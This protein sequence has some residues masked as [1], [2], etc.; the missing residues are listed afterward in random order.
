MSYAQMV[1]NSYTHM[2][3]DRDSDGKIL[4]DRA[5]EEMID[6]AKADQ[7]AEFVE[8][9][10]DPANRLEILHALERAA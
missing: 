5:I 9:L 4:L 6:L 10:Q 8:Y 7:Q 2:A 1:E 3:P